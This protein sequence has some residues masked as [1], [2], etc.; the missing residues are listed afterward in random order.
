MELVGL[1]GLVG[2]VELA[3]PTEPAEPE[4]AKEPA[5][6]AERNQKSK[7]QKPNINNFVYKSNQPHHPPT[8]HYLAH[9]MSISF[10][11]SYLIP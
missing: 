8:H 10:P 5:E 1:V 6:E 9:L 7:T 11:P 3:E 4:K 2:L